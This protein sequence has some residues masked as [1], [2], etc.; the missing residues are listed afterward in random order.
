M[1]QKIADAMFYYF[2][3]L[4]D[5]N[6][7]FIQLCAM[8]GIFV[9]DI[10]DYNQRVLDIVQG[11]PKLI[12]YIRDKGKLSLTKKDGL[13]EFENELS[14]LNDEYDIILSKNYDLLENV[15]LIRGKYAHKMHDIEFIQPSKG[16]GYFDVRFK[17]NDQR[18]NNGFIHIKDDLLMKLLKELNSLFSKIAK[19]IISSECV[20]NIHVQLYDWRIMRFD[21]TYFNEIYESGLLEKIASV[22]YQF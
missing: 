3:L 5:T 4:Y 20:N 13:L 1:N 22:M 11:I 21:F 7:N 8:G 14:Y 2:K 6:K 19:E 15:N 9:G 10:E 12:P 17:I 18:I 16:S